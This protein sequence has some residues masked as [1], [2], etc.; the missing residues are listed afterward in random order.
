MTPQTTLRTYG[1]LY[2]D[3]QREVAD[4]LE[5]MDNIDFEVLEKNKKVVEH[6]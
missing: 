6:L 2:P 3:K 4:S 1:H 5:E